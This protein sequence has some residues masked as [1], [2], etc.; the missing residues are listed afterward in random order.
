[1]NNTKTD[2][3]PVSGDNDAIVLSPLFQERLT[4]DELARL[5]KCESVIK[6]GLATFF[7]VGQAL[8]TIRLCGL[9]REG[10]P[11]FDAYCHARWGIGR[12]YACRLIGAAERV[13]LLSPQTAI[14]RPTTEF[15]IRPFLK[16]APEVFPKAWETAVTRSKNGKVSSAVIRAVIAEAVPAQ[17]RPTT[18]KRRKR[19]KLPKHCSIGEVLV[20]LQ[21]TRKAIEK[22]EH[23][24]ALAAIEKIDCLL[25]S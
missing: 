25:L 13:K 10:Y 8:L 17:T 1:M 22:G 12:S 20:L 9:Y 24:R 7:E 15:Q 19:T 6:T 23:Q 14:Q 21:E 3:R 11:T 5:E 4:S 2:A 16:L 18:L